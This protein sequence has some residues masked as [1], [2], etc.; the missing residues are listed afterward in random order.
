MFI[1]IHTLAVYIYTCAK[2]PHVGVREVLSK[3]C[4]YHAGE[5]MCVRVCVYLFNITTI[6][7]VQQASGVM[8]C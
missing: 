8:H 4:T 1:Y 2:R 6:F 3:C 7:E 5:N